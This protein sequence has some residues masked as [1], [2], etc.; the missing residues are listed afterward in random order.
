[1][2]DTRDRIYLADSK[3]TV[4]RKLG[5]EEN[6]KDEDFVKFEVGLFF[7]QYLTMGLTYQLEYMFSHLPIQ[8]PLRS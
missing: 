6:Q 5:L 2:A 8:D 3:V 7:S 4:R 1:M